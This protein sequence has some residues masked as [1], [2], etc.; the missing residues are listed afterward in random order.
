L[1]DQYLRTAI[2]ISAAASIAGISRETFRIHCLDTGLVAQDADG[3]VLLW[4][5]AKHLGQAID[6]DD[7]LLADSKREPE[8]RSQR[9][10]DRMKAA[11]R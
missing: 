4:S 5:L 1:K 10:R 2:S 8:R 11:A 7:V 3:R 9:A 6:M